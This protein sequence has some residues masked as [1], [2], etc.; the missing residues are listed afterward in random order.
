MII[1][2]LFIVGCT[3]ISSADN[4]LS[5][6]NIAS[7]TST[8]DS[9]STFISSTNSSTINNSTSSMESIIESSSSIDSI[10]S[11]ISN[12][13]FKV[14]L[15]KQN[16]I[17]GSIEIIVTFGQPMPFA[18]A[19]ERIGYY[20][21]GY[22]DDTKDGIR[23]YNAD[24]SSAKNWDKDEETTLYARWSVASYQVI[25]DRQQGY[26]GSDEVLATFEQPMPFAT[27]LERIGFIY[28]GY[29][30]LQDGQ[31]KKYYN[32]DMTSNGIWDKANTGRLY[33]FWEEIDNTNNL[34]YTMIEDGVGF[35]YKVKK[36]IDNL[37]RTVRILSMYKGL[38]VIKIESSGF[39]DCP[40]LLNIIF[41]NESNIKTIGSNAFKN[42]W[43]LMNVNIPDSVF[44]IG[45]STFSGCGYIASMSIPFVGYSRLAVNV[46]EALLGYIFETTE[47]DNSTAVTQF[48][49]SSST[50]IYYLPVSLK[51]IT[52]TSATILSYGAFSGCNKLVSVSIAKTV[53]TINSSIFRGCGSLT[54]LTIPFVGQIKNG[55]GGTMLLGWFFG[56]NSYTGGVLTQQ[57]SSSS[58]IAS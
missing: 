44:T 6:S 10:S 57:Y 15:D 5:T 49:S 55:D 27:A 2:S 23:Y 31:G 40:K 47:Y 32:A 50:I 41:E 37:E 24:M 19:P 18:I 22:F 52:V 33:A 30:E 9:T 21:L 43:R 16:G 13:T 56:G 11:S 54:N 35:A 38:P 34:I 8:I 17:R 3:N 26:G 29:Y 7:S 53:N 20:F 14:N 42:C 1:F 58:S 4:I 39:I 25:F 48:I 36:R 46:S 45:S 28:C 12:Q 51:T